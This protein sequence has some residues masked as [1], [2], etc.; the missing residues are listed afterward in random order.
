MD[1]VI[2]PRQ[3]FVWNDA[4]QYL[5]SKKYIWKKIN[6]TLTAT[7]FLDAIDSLHAKK[8]AY[9]QLSNWT[10]GYDIQEGCSIETEPCTDRTSKVTIEIFDEKIAKRLSSARKIESLMKKSDSLE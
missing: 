3:L 4:L 1:P 5:Q 2:S 10:N 9:E 6:N 8:L 7:F